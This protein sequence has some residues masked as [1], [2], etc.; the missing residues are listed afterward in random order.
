MREHARPGRHPLGTGSRRARSPL[1]PPTY[2][3]EPFEG[4]SE[5]SS[6]SF[7]HAT[8]VNQSV[9]SPT[10]PESPRRNLRLTAS[11]K[12]VTGVPAGVYLI[13]GS[14]PR[15]PISIALFRSL[16]I[17]SR[18]PRCKRTG[19]RARL[20]RP[21]SPRASARATRRARGPR[22]STRPGG[23]AERRKIVRPPLL[24]A[25]PGVGAGLRRALPPGRGRTTR[26]RPGSG[27]AASSPPSI[28][29]TPSS[30]LG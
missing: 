21:R 11:R 16:A 6:A 8:T 5:Q 22:A 12:L 4:C 1:P 9:C 2:T 17:A 13:S 30:P 29:H 24:E 23:S 25:P 7:C 18:P 14:A 20:P 3:L 27:R 15:R 28:T 26:S 10:S 19:H